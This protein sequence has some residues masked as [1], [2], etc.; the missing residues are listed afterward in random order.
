M[1]SLE[2]SLDGTTSPKAISLRWCKSHKACGVL[3][4]KKGNNNGHKAEA[5]MD[6]TL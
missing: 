3:T 5:G 6:S 2:S 4:S 1:D